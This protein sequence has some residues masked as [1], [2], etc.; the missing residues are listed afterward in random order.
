MTEC[1]IC[2]QLIEPEQEQLVLYARPRSIVF[3]ADCSRRIC[4][5]LE[6]IVALLDTQELL[7]SE[8]ATNLPC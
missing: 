7:E 5:A 3:C 2:S 8:P 4:R 6:A 1:R